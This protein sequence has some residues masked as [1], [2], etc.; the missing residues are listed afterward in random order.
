MA[1]ERVGRCVCKYLSAQF[2]L[3]YLSL[4]WLPGHNCG[5]YTE[6]VIQRES[7]PLT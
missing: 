4:A 1:F 6:R 3:L 2:Y 5:T 7:L